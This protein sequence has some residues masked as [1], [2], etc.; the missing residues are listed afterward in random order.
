MQLLEAYYRFDADEIRNPL[1]IL[2]M[3]LFTCADFVGDDL[4]KRMTSWKPLK[5]R[6][7]GTCL[8]SKALFTS[9]SIR[10]G[11]VKLGPRCFHLLDRWWTLSSPQP[12]WRC[13]P[14][15]FMTNQRW[16]R[17]QVKTPMTDWRKVRYC[18]QADGLE[19]SSVLRVCHTPLSSVLHAYKQSLATVQTLDSS[20]VSLELIEA[21]F[22]YALS[23]YCAKW[24]LLSQ[25]NR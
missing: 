17:L 2:P 12:A 18:E 11:I 20:L 4:S 8:F 14:G 25:D 7:N 21:D 5:N 6:G 19:H 23:R 3:A 16:K 9:R 24:V 15:T 22:V 1:K 10:S 13:N